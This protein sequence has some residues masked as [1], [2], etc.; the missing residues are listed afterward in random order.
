MRVAK[1]LDELDRVGLVDAVPELAV[2]VVDRLD[3]VRGAGKALAGARYEQLPS[4]IP[5]RLGREASSD[6]SGEVG[7][8][9]V[10]VV[11]SLP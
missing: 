6:V 5:L 3:V 11:D 4:N 7:A 2:A 1:L 10:E 8:E 9:G